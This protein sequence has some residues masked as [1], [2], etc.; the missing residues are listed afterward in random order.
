MASFPKP[1]MSFPYTQLHT[2][3]FNRQFFHL[4]IDSF[5]NTHFSQSQ[6]TYFHRDTSYIDVLIKRLI[7][8]TIR[9]TI[10]TP[11]Y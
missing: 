10:D 11:Q 8:F 7:Y 2:N 6:V 3:K 5:S 9:F 1:D 4:G